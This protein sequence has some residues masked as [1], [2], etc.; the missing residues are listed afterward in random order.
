MDKHLDRIEKAKNKAL[1]RLEYILEVDDAPDFVQITG[2][3]GGDI[4]T[5][6]FWDAGYVTER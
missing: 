4:V 6:R 2:S 3:V 5:Y 1:E